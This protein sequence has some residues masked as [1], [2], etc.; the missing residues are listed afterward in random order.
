MRRCL[1]AALLAVSVACAC[2]TA[3]GFELGLLTPVPAGMESAAR[4]AGV[5]L[6]AAVPEGA[7]TQLLGAGSLDSWAH[8]RFLVARAAVKGRKGLVLAFPPGSKDLS[9]YPE[10]WQ[11]LARVAREIAVMRPIMEAGVE[12]PVPFAVPAGASARAWLYK[13][14]LY[15]LMVNESSR[16]VPIAEETVRP[17]RA[18]FEVRTDARD[19]LIPCAISRCLGAQQ[20]LWLEGRLR[21][22]GE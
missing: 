8:L 22:R 7:D 17:W 13:R 19:L 1:S 10:E 14:R 9:V 2:E 16:A 5:S 12:T 18:L 15:V 4:T 11:A 21:W 3:L 6:H 20:V